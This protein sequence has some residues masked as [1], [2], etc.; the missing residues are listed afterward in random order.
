MWRLWAVLLLLLLIAVYG[1]AS[2]AASDGV[3]RPSDGLVEDFGEGWHRHWMERRL[4]RRPTRYRVVQDRGNVVLKAESA[5]SGSALWRMVSLY[6]VEQGTI[7][8]RWKVA[9]SL[10]SNDNETTKRGDDYAA[11][12]FVM[13][14]PDPFGRKARAICYVWAGRQAVGSVYPNPYASSV[15]T[16]VVESGDE[17]SGEWITEQRDFVTD[18]R[19]IFG[20]LPEMVTAV[21]VMVDTDDTDTDATAWFDDIALVAGA[22]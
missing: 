21:A 19:T 14:D 15:A 5:N 12:L 16:I 17:R 3:Q 11:R 22:S 4:S 13:F 6:P 20:E 18:F 2:A 9:M 7:T 8:W 1:A 10:S